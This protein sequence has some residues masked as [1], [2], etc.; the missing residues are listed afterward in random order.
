M[1]A[2]KWTVRFNDGVE[3]ELSSAEIPTAVELFSRADIKGSFD[4]VTYI[5]TA[6]IVETSCEMGPAHWTISFSI[7]DMEPQRD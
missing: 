5:A 1:G 3:A 6:T 7:E 2:A 4:G